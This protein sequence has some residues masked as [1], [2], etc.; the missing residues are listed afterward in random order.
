M[1][2]RIKNKIVVR[3]ISF[4][5]L[6]GLKNKKNFQKKIILI[7]SNNKDYNFFKSKK[8]IYR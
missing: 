6:N 1:A 4:K 2:Q 8:K 5:Y 3:S 7:N